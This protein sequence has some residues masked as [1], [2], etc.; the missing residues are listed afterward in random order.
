MNHRYCLPLSAR[1]A[2]RL[3]A[4]ILEWFYYLYIP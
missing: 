1:K 2:T 4:T 3:P